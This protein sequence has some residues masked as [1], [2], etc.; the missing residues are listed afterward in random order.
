M[1]AAVDVVQIE[2]GYDWPRWQVL[3]VGPEHTP[4]AGGVFKLEI[5][6]PREYPFRP[7]ELVF[8]TPI[9]HCNV[10]VNGHICN[11][12]LRDKWSPAMSIDAIL[13]GIISMLKHPHLEMAG[14]ER[15][16]LA[17]EFAKNRAEYDRKALECTK[18]TLEQGGV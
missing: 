3:L 17:A 13:I 7:P 2:L 14:V 8:K 1:G 18:A 9:Y 5:T 16:G 6:F 11:D 12:I 4:Y 15:R 10:G